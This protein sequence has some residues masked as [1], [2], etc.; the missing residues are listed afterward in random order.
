MIIKATGNLS[1][2][3]VKITAHI[4]SIDIYADPLTEKVFYNVLEN[5]LRHGGKLT[6]IKIF[7]QERSNGD[8]V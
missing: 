5:A 8:L 2:D 4:G 3:G 1:H 7:S 6:L